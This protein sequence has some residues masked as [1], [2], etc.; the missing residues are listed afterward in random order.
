MNAP[1]A[2][3][4]CRALFPS[5]GDPF[6]C[7]C[8][9]GVPRDE[10]VIGPGTIAEYD[11]LSRFHYR[12]SRPATCAAVLAAR[13]QGELVG[14]L[15]VSM[16]TLNGR[17]RELAWP[18]RYS[19]GDRRADIVRMNRELRTISRVV[20]DPRFRGMGVGARLVREYLRLPLTPATEAAATMGVC[21]PFFERAGMVRVRV[22]RASRDLL[23]ERKL[24][25]LALGPVELLRG[26]RL[27]RDVIDALRVWANAGRATRGLLEE[28][29]RDLARAAASALLASPVAYAH[30]AGEHTPVCIERA[31]LPAF[32]EDASEG[33]RCPRTTLP[34][35]PLSS[36]GKASRS[37][38]A[39]RRRSM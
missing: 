30:G 19:G 24:R 18:G 10:I 17:W 26:A 23:L 35:W 6:L 3:C 22:A 11:A 28:T 39:G 25:A 7:L 36:P 31:P 16:P 5:T 9:G 32:R 12:A 14:V 2:R 29:P 20:V 8:D 38:G 21:C 27:T 15:V 33:M 13:E 37:E 34:A 1:L 4:R